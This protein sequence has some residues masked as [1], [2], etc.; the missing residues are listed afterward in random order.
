MK[1]V[2]ARLLLALAAIWT[3]FGCA[4]GM[5]Q[6][7]PA[8]SVVTFT[9]ATPIV[10]ANN[11][12]QNFG[13]NRA[14]FV[15]FSHDMQTGTINASTFTVEGMTGNVSYDAVNR[16]AMFRPDTN[17]APGS[18]YLVTL[19]KSIRNTVGT[20]LA[21]DATF[22]VFTRTTIDS[23]TPHVV[24]P[25]TGCISPT[26]VIHVTFTDEMDSAT[27]NASTILVSGVTGTV[28][29]DALT[30]T[31]TF[32]PSAPFDASAS[33][34]VTVT[35]G[36]AEVGGAHLKSDFIFTVTICPDEKNDSFCS[37]T[38]GGYAGNGTPGSILTDNFATVFPGGMTIGINDGAGSQHNSIWTPD[39]TGIGA[40][41]SYLTS[42]AGGPS[43]A[44]TS[45]LTN[46]TATGSGQLSE[47]VAALTLNI[48]FAGSVSGMP[49]GFGALTLTGTG[50]SLD[51]A[52]VEQILAIANNSLAGNGLPAGYTFSTLNDLVTNLNESWDNCTQDTWAA[53][54]LQ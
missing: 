21:L 53:A 26:G 17:F 41:R 24:P 38:K 28:T 46:P 6:S 18:P 52:T 44:L 23:S 37:Y 22:K 27:I 32:T 39:A 42:P 5:Q 4:G 19:S 48:N 43:A 1:P 35:T 36:V 3:M 51:G 13:T 30:K 47:Q 29:Y 10:I 54:H 11:H 50:T 2:I 7:T 40:L 15:Q 20:P 45:D 25:D 16:I 33:Y 31:A 49:A 34:T 12:N 14:I 9:A 8:E